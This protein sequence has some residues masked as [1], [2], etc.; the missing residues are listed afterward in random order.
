M[1]KTITLFSMA[2]FALCS[3]VAMAGNNA[4]VIIPGQDLSKMPLRLDSKLKEG[5]DYLPNTIILKVK[6]AFRQ[7]C[8]AN[9][10]SGLLP[11]EDV[12]KS[13]GTT[14]LSKIYPNDRPPLEKVNSLGQEHVDLSLIYT[15]QYNQS[16][17]LEKAINNIKRL[18]YFEYVEPRYVY[19]VDYT[20]NDPSYSNA[21]QYFCKGDVVGSINTQQAWDVTKGDPSV[22]IGIVDT[23]TEPN[24]PDL[25]ANYVGGYD[26]A[27]NDADPTWQGNAHGVA[28][29]GDACAVTDNGVGVASPGFN[30]KF[31]VAKIANASGSLVADYEGIKWA[32]DNGCKIIN[33]SWGGPGGGQYG[34][35]IVNYAAINKNCLVIVSA[36]NTNKDEKFYPSSYVNAYRVAASD[37]SDARSTFSTYGWDVDYSSPGTGIYSTYSNNSYA[38]LNG[39]SMAGPVSAG[40]A[41]LI[42]SQF[43]YTNAFQIGEKLK[44][45]CD[46]MAN[47]TTTQTSALYA[48]NKLGKGRI[49]V[50]RALTENVESIVLTPVTVTDGGDDFFLPAET[51]SV[52]GVFTNY[53]DPCSSGATATLSVASVSSGTAPTIV[54]GTFT[55][56]ALAT[57]ATN[58]NN[59]APFKIVV[60]PTAGI[61]QVVTLLVTITDGAF[62][63]KHYFDFIVNEDCIHITNN[64]VHTTITSTG[65]IGY[66]DAGLS[67]GK[68][69]TYI[70][71]NGNQSLLYEMSLMIGSS[72]TKVSDMFRD[73]IKSDVD[74]ASKVR[75]DTILPATL[76]D[77]D[78]TGKFADNI[79]PSPLPVEVRHTAH[80]WSTD[81]YRK[82]VMVKYFIKNTSANALLNVSVGLIADWD[83]Q[84]SGANK[85]AFDA[86]NNMGYCWGTGSTATNYYAGIK[87]L[88]GTANNNCIDNVKGGN[89][90]IDMTGKF[91]ESQKY[92]ALTVSRNSD[93]FTATGGD[94]SHCVSKK[95]LTIVANDSVEVAFA[96]LAGDNLADLQLSANAAQEKYNNSISISVQ[97]T[98]KD[99][100]WMISYPN[101]SSSIVH[102]SYYLEESNASLQIINTLGETIM[103]YNHLA[104]GKNT[105]SMDASHLS[106]GT[107]FYQLKSSHAVLN[108]KFS[109]VK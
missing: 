22:I 23:G 89:G 53:L 24:H 9:A 27:M 32:A 49:D 16:I 18:G 19:H 15:L 39:T 86:T 57:L 8:T 36:G 54:N 26:V 42:Q 71:P 60:S 41:G 52:S 34:Q 25:K 5:I 98:E 6:P 29:S 73:T 31:K 85:S 62:T 47:T 17:A 69:F 77:F 37:Q 82:F 81:P 20:P 104:K 96:I 40:A 46:P 70:T 95:G 75:V 50:Y 102:F 56:G 28:V 59:S 64:A 83:I 43:N 55:I 45:T 7:N 2:L 87:L 67:R 1:K 38:A 4:R 84:N 68:G 88:N 108:K 58:N 35:D 33:N 72:S 13:I 80:A 79:A 93:G 76:S 92:L 44:Q 99:N 94:V 78:V 51:L 11:L 21:G 74:F 103:T 66:N 109:I 65:R 100:F 3:T 63:G 105:L 107:Y 61:N 14:Q 30:C 90:G 12:L 10:I 48:A 91:P 101:P 106:A 97:E